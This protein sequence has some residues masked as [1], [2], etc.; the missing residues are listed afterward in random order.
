MKNTTLDRYNKVL[1]NTSFLKGDRELNRMC[2]D[3]YYKCG[4]VITRKATAEEQRKYDT[5][6][7]FK[8]A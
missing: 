1:Y 8:V 2:R 7:S 5:L 3:Y 4:A 6:F